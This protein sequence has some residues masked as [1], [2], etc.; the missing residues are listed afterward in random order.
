MYKQFLE[1]RDVTRDEGRR[2]TAFDCYYLC[3]M[4]NVREQYWGK[5]TAAFHITSI[6]R[7]F[8]K[9]CINKSIHPSEY[10]FFFFFCLSQERGVLWLKDR[11][12]HYHNGSFQF[13][14]INMLFFPQTWTEKAPE[15][16]L[17]SE[18]YPESFDLTKT[19]TCASL[20]WQHA[21]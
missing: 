1:I 16:M 21:E 7:G 5:S 15:I 2:S 11:V 13:F 3:Q 14:N 18:K 17:I 8:Q 10:F 6:A 20:V 12:W 19:T 4:V 9:Y